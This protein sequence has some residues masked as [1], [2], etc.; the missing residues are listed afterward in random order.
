MITANIFEVRHDLRTNI[1]R[2]RIGVPADIQNYG[3]MKRVLLREK[4]TVVKAWG[5]VMQQSSPK[6]LGE[7]IP[8]TS[9]SKMSWDIDLRH[10]VSIENKTAVL[11]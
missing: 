9:E 5:N 4:L 7:K 2:Q 3:H 6:F 10:R 1:L 11:C 8:T